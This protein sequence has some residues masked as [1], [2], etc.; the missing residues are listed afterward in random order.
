M[1]HAH[2]VALIVLTLLP[3]ACGQGGLDQAPNGQDEIDAGQEGA[4]AGNA[5]AGDGGGDIVHHE[6]DGGPEPQPTLDGG[7]FEAEPDGGSVPDDVVMVD[8]FPFTHQG[9]T[10]LSNRSNWDA[11]SCAP[12]LDES[13]PEV[14]Y[15][16]VVAEGGT[17]TATVEDGA[18]VDVDLH[19]LSAMDPET[20][21]I[22]HD[23]SFSWIVPAGTYFLAA[24][25][26]VNSGGDELSGSY[27]LAL[28]LQVAPTTVNACAMKT[29]TLEMFWSSCSGSIDGCDQSGANPVLTLPATGPVV[30]EAHLVTVAESF[31]NTWPAASRD[32]IENHYTLSE[33]ASGYTM[34]RTEDWAPAG[35]GGSEYGQ[36]STGS[37]VPVLDEAF[38][39]TMYWRQ[40]PPEG[41]RMIVFNPTNGKAV[42]ASA[43]WETGPGSNTAVAGVSEEIHHHL[44]TVHRSTLTV[45]FAENEALPLGP[46]ECMP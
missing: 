35:E 20:C 42:V 40:R 34:A 28:D 11:Y 31:P 41:T 9:D 3:A 19:L 7:G 18:G 23:A 37:K 8:A 12:H 36:G 24:D 33:S 14:V 17:L 10:A 38:Y 2:L 26:Y 6:G 13:G 25:T 15:Q 30:K 32:G 39:I 4:E 44:G 22:R 45:G 16:L 43:G 29:S 27:T 5:Q 1:R 46:V 21:L